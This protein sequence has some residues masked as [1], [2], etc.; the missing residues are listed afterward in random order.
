MV[1]T[2]FHVYRPQRSC[3]K[4]MFL[5]LSVILFTGGSLSRGR[6][7]SVGRVSVQGSLSKGSLYPEGLYLGGLYP[8]LGSLSRGL[9]L[10]GLYPRG[11]L[12]GEVSVW[13]VS[14]QVEGLCPGVSVWKFLS[15]GYLFRWLGRALDMASGGRVCS[16]TRWLMELVLG[17]LSRSVS[18]KGG[19]L[20]VWGVSI[21]EGDLCQWGLCQERPPYGNVRAVCILLECILVY[22][23]FGSVISFC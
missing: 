11:S 10:W 21:Q 3:G 9:C 17:T 5:H 23:N 4:V 12:S 15:G 7:L 16:H 14:V 19:G 6:S 22:F 18:V 13:Q 1:L 8:G 20:P 2:I